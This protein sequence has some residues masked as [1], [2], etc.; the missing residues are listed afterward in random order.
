[1]HIDLPEWTIGAA[2]WAAMFRAAGIVFQPNNISAPTRALALYRGVPHN[3]CAG[4]A[5]SVDPANR[6]AIPS[7]L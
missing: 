5:W 2:A 7:V 4:M 3:R 6:R 1:M